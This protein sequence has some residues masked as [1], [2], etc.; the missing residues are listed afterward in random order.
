[1]LGLFSSKSD[2]P[3]FDLKE[4]KKVAAAI[5]AHEPR[6]AVEES[7]NWLES[8]ASAEG[9]KL[10]QRLERVMLLDEAT[11]PAARRFAREYLSHPRPNRTLEI[12][13]WEANHSYWVQLVSAYANCLARYRLPEKDADQI[14]PQ[15]PLLYG[16]IMS[17]LAA[18]LKWG[19]FRYGPISPEFWATLGSVYLAAVETKV[20]IKPLI[21]Y[22][23]SDETTIEAE[24][25]KALV[26]QASSMDNLTP[27]EIEL[28][29]RFVGYFLPFFSL[30]RE[31]RP[32]NVYWVDAAKPLPPTRLAKL[33]EVTP[34]LRFFNGTRAVEAV[35]K[36]VAQIRSEG[37]V[38][39]G[40]NLGSSYA[41]ASVI[42]VLEHLAMCWAPKPPMRTHTRHRVK[43]RLS[44]VHGLHVVHHSLSGRTGAADNAEAWLVDDVSLGGMGAVVPI[45]RND[46]IRIGAL[47][48]MQPEGGDNW[49]LGVIRRYTRTGNSEGSVGI[50]TLSKAPRAIVADA[51]G[52]QTECLLLD[53]LVVGENV[54]MVL[55]PSALEDR[56]ALIFTLD[57]QRARLHPLQMLESGNDFAIANFVVQSYN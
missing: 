15:L 16:R 9:F 1:M 41:P 53:A 19:Q 11:L 14:K 33:P 56:V 29:E 18:Q 17:G 12:Q 52:L 13:L 49:L 20:A 51:G 25:L 30:I 3:L 44:V 22:P 39:G 32:E 47:V 8:L 5:A 43:S 7:G 10:A 23:G 48:G 57:R 31:V 4:A 46:W 21:L 24:Y 6:A 34:T 40:I 42:P 37:R 28:G 27:P 36:T 38:P 54:R 2:H 45:T 26:F 35:E 50:E 55:Q